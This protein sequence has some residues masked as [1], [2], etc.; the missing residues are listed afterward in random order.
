MA[1]QPPAKAEAEAKPEKSRISDEEMLTVF[2][3]PAL[4][5]NKVYITI[6]AG[7]VRLTF[8]E[9]SGKAVPPKFRTAVLLGFPD[10]LALRDLLV[11]QLEHVKVIIEEK[12]DGSK[13]G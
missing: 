8:C 2:S 11:R 3:G 4:A 10:A 6:T 9:Q 12:S 7:G 1:E 13:D 5:S